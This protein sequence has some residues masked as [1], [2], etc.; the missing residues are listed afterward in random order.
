MW[1]K[2]RHLWINIGGMWAGV[3]LLQRNQTPWKPMA[4]SKNSVKQSAKKKRKIEAAMAKAAK[5]D[6]EAA[7][8]AAESGQS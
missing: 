3:F 5:R 1:W 4:P 7:G 8:A 2:K 6:A